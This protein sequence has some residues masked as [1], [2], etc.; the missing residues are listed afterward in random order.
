MVLLSVPLHKLDEPAELPKQGQQ[1]HQDDGDNTPR[2]SHK[3]QGQNPDGADESEPA[4]QHEH[5]ALEAPTD[6]VHEGLPYIPLR[7]IVKLL[8]HFDRLKELLGLRQHNRAVA[9]GAFVPHDEFTSLIV[10]GLPQFGHRMFVS[11]FTLQCKAMSRATL[12]GK[13]VFDPK[14]QKLKRGTTG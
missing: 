10:I 2:W 14:I 11:P 4:N 3:Q 13:P 1:N 12:T 5:D 6:P 9:P 7:R 8:E